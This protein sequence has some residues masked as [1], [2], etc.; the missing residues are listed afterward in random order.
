MN[1]LILVDIQNDFLPSGALPVPQGDAIIK[2][3]NP[4][5][6][7]FTHVVATQDWHPPKHGSFASQ[8]DGHDA[9]SI[10]DLHGLSQVLWPDHCVQNTTGSEFVSELN[11]QKIQKIVQKGT[12]PTVDSYSGFADNGGRIET[13]LDSY[14]KANSIDTLY[15]C[16]LA[17]D[18][19]V[20]FTAH[21][22]LK[23]GYKTY[24]ITDA[25]RGIDPAGVEAALQSL[26]ESGASLILSSEI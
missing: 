16:G 21:D 22:A 8:H 7:Q 3:V 11:S 15:I 26:K 25:C 10:I 9:F 14:L 4:L 19:C 5:L 23:R 6:D 13:E 17:T 1:A 2:V 20:Q 24:I 18:Y 12:D